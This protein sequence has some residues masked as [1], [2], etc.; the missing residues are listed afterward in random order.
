MVVY[1][2]VIGVWVVTCEI[3]N[4]YHQTLRVYS[5]R[6]NIFPRSY[7]WRSTCVA[8]ARDNGV[9][10]ALKNTPHQSVN[11]MQPTTV[12]Y[13][14]APSPD[15][16][17]A[18]QSLLH[19]SWCK[20][21]LHVHTTYSDGSATPMQLVDHVIASTDVTVIAVTDHDEIAGAYI[22][23]EYAQ[24]RGLD[25][26]IGEEISSREGHILAYFIHERIAPGMTASDTIRAIHEQGGIAVAAHPYDWM[27]RSLGRYGLLERA[28][29]IQPEWAF[30]AIET[31]NSS[32]FPRYANMTAHRV[33]QQ[34]GLP[35]IGGSDSHQLRTVGYGYTQYEGQNADDLRTALRYGRTVPA[36]ANWSY[37]DLAVATGRL[38]QRV[39]MA[40][41]AMALRSVGVV[42]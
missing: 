9:P 10:S 24:G 17:V 25:V 40:G 20:A 33:A 3:Y 16:I 26:I 42:S 39:S 13:C 2:H 31:L 38:I 35:M 5:Y 37:T 14:D 7:T 36:G 23:R 11:A 29:G 15:Y 41:V 30:D 22:A 32:L 19:I 18:D 21:D 34:L 1:V 4:R 6:I 27:V 8:V 12:V 28:V